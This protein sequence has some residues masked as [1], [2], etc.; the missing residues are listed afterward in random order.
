[1]K[2]LKHTFNAFFS[3][4]PVKKYNARHKLL[5]FLAYKWGFRLYNSNLIWLN[6]TECLS[7]LQKFKPGTKRI[8][9]RKYILYSLAKSVKDLAGNTAECGVF[10]GESS[11]LICWLNQQKQ[12]YHHHA[13]DS[14]E[15]LSRP[16]EF[17]TPESK[18]AYKWEKHDL[19]APLDLVKKNLERFNFVVYHKGWIPSQFGYVA[20]LQ[21]SFVHIDVD[22]YE[23]THDSLAFF[24]ER[25]VPGGII[26]SDDYGSATCPGSKRAFDEFLRDKPE[27][28]IPLTTGQAFIVKQ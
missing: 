21:F 28:V 4:D 9:D 17:D 11:F 13:F 19:T 26:L 1:M 3:G 22:L 2:K 24:Y 15:G 7:V 20:E 12:D 14:Y 8:K 23:P 25:M 6:D 18:E 10:R 16:G 27:T 5:S